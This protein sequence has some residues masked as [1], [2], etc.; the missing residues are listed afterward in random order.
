MLQERSELN[1]ALM[2]GLNKT[3]EEWG[4][5]SLGVEI[6][7]LDPPEEIKKSMQKQIEAE[8]TKR[9]DILLSEGK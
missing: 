3:A 9:K 7:S 8:R 1:E 5:K 6:L 4:L 2:L